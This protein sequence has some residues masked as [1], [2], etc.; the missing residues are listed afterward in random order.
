[1]KFYQIVAI[2]LIAAGV[3]GLI[4]GGFS[5]VTETHEAQVGPLSLAVNERETVTVPL[6]I[7]I[8]GIF[9]GAMMLLLGRKS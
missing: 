6:W 1:M 2:V 9:I 3:L 7:G 5:F 8:A 4:Y